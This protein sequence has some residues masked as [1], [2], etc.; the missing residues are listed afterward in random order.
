[1]KATVKSN[2]LTIIAENDSESAILDIWH[3]MAASGSGLSFRP[4]LQDGGT[5]ETV[6]QLPMKD[7]IPMLRDYAEKRLAVAI[8]ELEK[9]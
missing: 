8:V 7:L 1:M 6:M 3:D 5:Q 2:A 9:L 4:F